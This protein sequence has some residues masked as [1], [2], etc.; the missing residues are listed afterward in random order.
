MSPARHWRGI[1]AAVVVAVSA[2][3]STGIGCS[4]AGDMTADGA[5]AEAGRDAAADAHVAATGTSCAADGGVLADGSTDPHDFTSIWWQECATD[6]IT[7]R[8]TPEGDATC[9]AWAPQFVRTGEVHSLCHRGFCEAVDRCTPGDSSHESECGC[10]S[11]A[12]LGCGPGMFCWSATPGDPPGCVAA[13]G[14]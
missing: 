9:A 5:A 2:A 6:G 8:G 12:N 14:G 1:R 11:F 7:A 10:G 3:A 13:C 4:A